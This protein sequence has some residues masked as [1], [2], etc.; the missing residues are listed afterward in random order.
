VLKSSLDTGKDAEN[1]TALCRRFFPSLFADQEQN[2]P[3]ALTQAA[4]FEKLKV[5][6]G[7]LRKLA[8]KDFFDIYCQI[9]EQI[10]VGTSGDQKAMKTVDQPCGKLLE[11]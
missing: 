2:E 3:L 7:E 11:T 5:D 6:F 8:G 10:L 1:A 4:K 9:E